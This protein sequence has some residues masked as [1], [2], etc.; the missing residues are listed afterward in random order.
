MKTLFT[1]APF[2][3]YQLGWDPAPDLGQQVSPETRYVYSVIGDILKEVGISE[4]DI[5]DL[6]NKIP[7]ESAGPYRAKLEECKKKGLTTAEGAAC[8]YQLYKEIKEGKPEPAAPKL[9][10]P[11]P[12]SSFPVVPVMLGLAAAGGLVYFLATRGK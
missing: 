11:A 4:S 10:P 5:N 3:R 12:P 9:P 7:P 2:A 6:I 8:A 1:N